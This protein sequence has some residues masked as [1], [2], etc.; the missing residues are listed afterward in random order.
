MRILRQVISR[1]W[2][3]TGRCGFRGSD[4]WFGC[5]MSRFDPRLG[6]GGLGSA[7]APWACEELRTDSDSGS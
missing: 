4:L 7:S 2:C 6:D 3:D 1:D 5:T